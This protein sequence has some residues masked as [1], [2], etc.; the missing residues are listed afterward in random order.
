VNCAYNSAVKEPERP[1]ERVQQ[2]GNKTECAMLGWVSRM[3]DYAAIRRSHPEESHVRCFTFN[4]TRKSMMTGESCLRQSVAVIAKRQQQQF[5]IYK[6]IPKFSV[7]N[8]EA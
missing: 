5:D 6:Y 3:G 1:G 8:R 7:K 4:S 2:L